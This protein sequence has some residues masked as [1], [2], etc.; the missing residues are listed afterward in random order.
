M[1]HRATE[2]EWMDLPGVDSEV[3][4]RVLRY[5]EFVNS[6]LGGNLALFSGLKNVFK[7]KPSK[8]S[9][10]VLDLGCG[11]GSQ[12]LEINKWAANNKYEL[13]LIGLDNNE[14]AIRSAKKNEKKGGIQFLHGD[15]LDPDFDYG[16]Y[17]VVVCNLFLHHLNNQQIAQ[18]MHRWN[19]CG[20]T[21]LINDLQRSVLAVFL[22]KL[23]SAFTMA[24]KMAKHDGVLSIKKGF[25]K[26]EL[27]ALAMDA[28]FINF[29]IKWLWAF[30]LQLL[31][32]HD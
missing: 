3:L 25:L 14:E 29:Q 9:W 18:I 27:T 31:L 24:P 30:R 13:E 4:R 20:A 32:L 10:K 16:I 2:T 8:T 15:A 17:D 19:K 12:L 5:L 22:F 28:G 23:F 6:A 26:N 11:S 21:V 7:Q 1:K